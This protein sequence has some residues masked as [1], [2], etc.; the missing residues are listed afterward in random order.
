MKGK[1]LFVFIPVTLI[2]IVMGCSQ[3]TPP[4]P[5][6]TPTPTVHPGKKLVNSRCVACHDISRVTEK[7]SD[8]EGWEMTVDRM[9]LLGADLNDEQRD[10]VI[11]YLV[12]MYPEE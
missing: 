4:E 5:T 6:A 3:A 12:S 9:I 11:D 1:I 8:R 2:M 7:R 10:Q